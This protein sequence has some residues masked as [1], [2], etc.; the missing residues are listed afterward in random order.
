MPISS[1]PLLGVVGNV[2]RVGRVE[3]DGR[4]GVLRL[5]HAREESAADAAALVL[6]VDG[7]E[8]QIHVLVVRMPLLLDG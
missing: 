5:I 4:L 3:V 6:R 1:K 2:G 8:P 7:E